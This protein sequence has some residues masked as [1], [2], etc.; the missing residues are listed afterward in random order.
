MMHVPPSRSMEPVPPGTAVW[1]PPVGYI[2]QA[3]EAAVATQRAAAAAARMDLEREIVARRENELRDMY[4]HAPS[5]DPTQMSIERRGMEINALDRMLSSKVE[6]RRHEQEKMTN[7]IAELEGNMSSLISRAKNVISNI[8][9]QPH[10]SFIEPVGVLSLPPHPIPYHKVPTTTT[11]TTMPPPAVVPSSPPPA[12]LQPQPQQPQHHTPVPMYQAPPRPLS[13]EPYFSESALQKMQKHFNQVPESKPAV[14]VATP[15]KDSKGMS[16]HRSVRWRMDPHHPPS[17]SA[18]VRVPSHSHVSHV[19]HVFQPAPQAS[20]PMPLPPQ[21]ILEPPSL[22]PQSELQPRP[23]QA[24]PPQSQ[25]SLPVS[26]QPELSS[27]LPGLRA[28]VASLTARATSPQTT[29]NNVTLAAGPSALSSVALLAASRLGVGT[30]GTS[31]RSAVRAWGEV[32][33]VRDLQNPASRQGNAFSQAYATG[34]PPTH[35]SDGRS[36]R[37]PSPPVSLSPPYPD[38]EPHSRYDNLAPRFH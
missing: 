15:S 6:D 25:H 36:R 17:P 27:P 18:G 4:S 35:H 34:A 14:E 29:T 37:T 16:P 9:P 2:N 31:P 28:A 32:P 13:P 22:P 10:S 5:L 19:P 26:T 7:R 8:A 23:S 3:R 12:M 21:V 20:T 24:P 1:D 11:T 30:D 33:P 38:P